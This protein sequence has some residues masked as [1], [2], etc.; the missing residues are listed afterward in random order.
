MTDQES[1]ISLLF[2]S[3]EAEFEAYD[4]I[5][6]KQRAEAKLSL[7]TSMIRDSKGLIK[8][9]EREARV[10]GRP[11]DEIM[12]AKQRYVNQVNSY[13]A[14]KKQAAADLKAR[15]QQST[16]P[17]P[18]SVTASAYTTPPISSEQQ[19]LAQKQVQGVLTVPLRHMDVLISPDRP[20]RSTNTP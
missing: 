18:T 3:I 4:R 8:E 6:D 9:F 2:K 7:L 12:A 11:T 5:D 14:R 1:N 17:P 15:T 20:Q 16:P 13:V 10:D 19:P